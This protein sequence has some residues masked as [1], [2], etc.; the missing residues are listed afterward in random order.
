MINDDNLLPSGAPLPLPSSR[1]D[2]TG[3]SAMLG[4]HP[5]RF[6]SSAVT[7]VGMVRKVNE[8]AVLDQSG[9]GMWAVADGMGGHAAGDFASRTIV[10]TLSRLPPAPTISVYV[11]SVQTSLQ[12]INELL[13]QEAARRE[14][15]TIGATVAVLVAA[16][17]E[18]A[19]LWAGDSRLYRFR[20][21]KLEQ[22][23][24]DHSYVQELVDAGALSPEEAQR[25][26]MGNV[27]TRAVGA[28][29]TLEVDAHPVITRPGDVLLLCTDG[30]SKVVSDDEI[31][32]V[33]ATR[34][35]AEA[36]R[37]LVNLAL[38]RGAPDNVS[39]VVVR[40]DVDTGTIT[41]P[42]TPQP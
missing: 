16:A 31:A 42:V 36:T 5:L 30:L 1:T 28:H 37:E 14:R 3:D 21:P 40:V 38:L 12:H 26:P 9:R 17:D 15:E 6:E 2:D 19:C 33:L 34:R 22:L 13:R 20:R 41:R 8:D 25:H 4:D 11:R 29:E 10:Q 24:R 23:T 35:P 39:L 32:Q 7:H 27:V 18:L